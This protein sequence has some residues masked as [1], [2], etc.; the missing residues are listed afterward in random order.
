MLSHFSC[1]R[2]F[3][4][5]WTVAHQVP[6]ST[7]FSRQE[8]WS[9]FPC[10]PPGTLPGPGI[11]P[12]SLTS[13]ALAASFFITSATWEA[14]LL[15]TFMVILGGESYSWFRCIVAYAFLKINVLCKIHNKYSRYNPL[16]WKRQSVLVDM[17]VRRVKQGQLVS[18]CDA[19]RGG[20]SETGMTHRERVWPP[21]G[22]YTGAA[23]RGWRCVR[24][25]V[26]TELNWV[27]FSVHL[28]CFAVEIMDSQA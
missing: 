10:P 4:T 11:E 25:C 27:Q 24:L 7:G 12:T 2:L 17:D 9:G 13:P 22:L 18:Y 20:L 8:Y 16:P 14:Q 19:V 15:S 28:V 1:V 3:V 5:L 26:W 21:H 23:G 6:L